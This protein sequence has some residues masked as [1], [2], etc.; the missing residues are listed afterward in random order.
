MDLYIYFHFGSV[1]VGGSPYFLESAI[2]IQKT[3]KAGEYITSSERISALVSN[4]NPD[5]LA[6]L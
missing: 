3:V 6:Y 2:A 4:P 1:Y 5:I